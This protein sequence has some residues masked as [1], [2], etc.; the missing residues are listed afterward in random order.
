M[1][2]KRGVELTVTEERTCISAYARDKGY[3]GIGRFTPLILPQYFLLK[4][5]T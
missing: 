4:K 3:I 2:T 1:M 5:S